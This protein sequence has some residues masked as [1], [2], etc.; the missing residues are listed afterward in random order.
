MNSYISNIVTLILSVI[1]A[2]NINLNI[3]DDTQY[4]NLYITRQEDFTLYRER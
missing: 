1:R 4:V 3:I 2:E